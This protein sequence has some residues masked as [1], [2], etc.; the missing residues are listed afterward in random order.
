MEENVMEENVM[1][2]EAKQWRCAAEYGLTQELVHLVKG[3]HTKFT[4]AYQEVMVPIAEH[5][6]LVYELGEM[7]E[8]LDTDYHV[9]MATVEESLLIKSIIGSNSDTVVFEEV[10][11]LQT[12][13]RLHVIEAFLTFF[14]GIDELVRM[15]N[16]SITQSRLLSMQQVID[17]HHVHYARSSFL[18]RICWDASNRYHQ[19]LRIQARYVFCFFVL[20]KLYVCVLMSFC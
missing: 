17:T 11:L 19:R 4:L 5:V 18:K 9:K 6:E 7:F 3:L 8:D 15:M 13:L 16:A 10:C 14:F 1:E 20:N 2:K 12:K